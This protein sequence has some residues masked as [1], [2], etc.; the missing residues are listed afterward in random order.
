MSSN[1]EDNNVTLEN[2]SIIKL[3][4]KPQSLAST[5]GWV[6]WNASLVVIRYLE[7]KCP[8]DVHGLRVADL[9]TGNGLVAIAAAYLGASSVIATEVPTCSPLTRVN[10]EENPNV[11]NRIRVL[12]YSWGD[13]VCPIEGCDLVVGSDLLFIAIRDN[14][15]E[16]LHKTLVDICIANKKLLFCYEE[17]IVEKEQAFMVALEKD[18]QVN[19]VPDDQIHVVDDSQDIFYEP[20][21]IRMYILTAKAS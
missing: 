11:Q 21:I 14:I 20:A 17:R 16:Q 8:S 7:R 10:V 13:V 12:D 3:H 5:T 6:T 4:S 19:C 1:D 18:L 2:G 15:Y 9:S